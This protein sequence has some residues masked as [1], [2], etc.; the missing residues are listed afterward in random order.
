MSDVEKLDVKP[1]FIVNNV[2][3]IDFNAFLEGK[4]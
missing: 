1:E 2:S 4:K 3:E